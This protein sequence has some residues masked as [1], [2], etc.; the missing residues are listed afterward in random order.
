MKGKELGKITFLALKDKVRR[1]DVTGKTLLLPDMNHAGVRLLAASFR[2]FGVNARV[3][4]T[5]AGLALGR[6]FTSGKECFPCQITL[7][8][9]LNHLRKEKE[10]LGP[11]FDPSRYVYFLPEADGPCRF[12]MYNK[13]QRII[14]DSFPEFHKIP[15]TYLSTKDA[16]AVAGLLP[17]EKARHF[18]RTAFV[19]IVIADVWDRTLWRVRPYEKSPGAMD[20]LYEA[21]L[22]ELCRTVEKYGYEKDFSTMRKRLKE[23]V[24]DAKSL[25]DPAIPR[26]PRIGIV[27][28]IYL[29]CHTKAN[30]EV[31]RIIEKYGGE[32]VNASLTEWFNYISYDN[33]SKIKKVWRMALRNGQWSSFRK[34][35][36][37]WVT[38]LIEYYYQLWRQGQVYRA[39]FSV[40]DIAHDHSINALENRLGPERLLCFDVGTEAALSI[41][42]AIVYAQEGFDGVVN[43]FPFTCMPSTVTS[44]VLK[45]LLREIRIPYID[46]PYDGTYQPNRDA[47]VR[48]FMYQAHQHTQKKNRNSKSALNNFTKKRYLADCL[49]H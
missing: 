37:S 48:T 18:R 28:E 15:I 10:S 8:D 22:D 39:S 16:Y 49:I 35:L 41:A 31:I 6:E 33:A 38:Q 26:K 3:M 47:I 24:A 34:N 1:F 4:E 25:I 14:L 43:V 40:L 32:V 9:I 46:S 36:K 42:G 5:Y 27:G 23:L 13:F 29:R 20:R 45:P 44:A 7:G 2:A 19:G 30:Q 12:G 17:A 21:G 11:S